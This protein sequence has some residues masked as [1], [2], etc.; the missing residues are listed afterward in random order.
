MHNRW[1]DAPIGGIRAHDANAGGRGEWPQTAGGVNP[2][3]EFEADA[4]G[5][6][7]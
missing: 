4:F 1:N 2:E 3:G 7:P 6:P 5:T